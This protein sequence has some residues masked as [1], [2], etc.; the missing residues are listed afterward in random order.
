VPKI[1]AR[2]LHLEEYPSDFIIGLDIIK[3]CD[4]H[5]DSVQK[6]FSFHLFPTSDAPN[7]QDKTDL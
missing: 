5:Y 6:S 4:F 1:E 2:L 3:H 7:L